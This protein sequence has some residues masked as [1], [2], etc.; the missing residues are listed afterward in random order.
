MY[1]VIRQNYFKILYKKYQRNQFA[2]MSFRES[3]KRKYVY[4]NSPRGIF[5]E[6][7]SSFDR[8][9][10]SRMVGYVRMFHLQ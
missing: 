6:G 2:L 10:S 4:I 9:H 7:V 8:G 1:S 3:R 5:R